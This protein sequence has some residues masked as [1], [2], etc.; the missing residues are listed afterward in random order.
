MRVGFAFE[1]FYVVDS[2]Y[3]RPQLD[4]SLLVD[5][6]WFDIWTLVYFTT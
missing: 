5:N 2:A 3:V 1:Y 4:L 6:T